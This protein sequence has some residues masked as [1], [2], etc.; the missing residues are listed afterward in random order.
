MI[1]G[2]LKGVARRYQKLVLQLWLTLIV[3]EKFTVPVNIIFCLYTLKGITKPLTVVIF[4]LNTLCD[5][6]HQF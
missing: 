4:D 1:D 2:I 3:P 6:K 5:T